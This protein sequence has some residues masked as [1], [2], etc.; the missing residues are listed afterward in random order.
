M[1]N[2]SKL[3]VLGAGLAC[4]DL[5]RYGKNEFTDLGGTA[6]NV[7]STLSLLGYDASFLYVDYKGKDSKYLKEEIIKRKIRLIQFTSSKLDAP[8][9][10]EYLDNG[11]HRFYTTCPECGKKL[12]EIQLPKLKHIEEHIKEIGEVNLFYFDRI[13]AGIKWLAE[14]NTNGWNFYEPNSTRLYNTL[15]E[16]SQYADILKLSADRIPI[17]Y[18]EKLKMDIG[19]LGPK[20]LIVSLGSNG[21]KYSIKQKDGNLSD[22]IYLEMR[23]N[24]KVI[25]SS[26]A[27]DF[28]A[29]VFLYYFLKE[30]PY[31]TE[32]LDV[33]KVTKFLSYAQSV[34]SISCKFIGAQGILESV[35]GVNI[36]NFLLNSCVEKMENKSLNFSKNCCGICKLKLL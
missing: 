35:E 9:I 29:S 5:I 36:L 34:A 21:L 2:L 16:N 22:W 8:R 20:L 7:I 12:N 18:I 4:I 15:L 23:E 33:A 6:V 31:Y 3:K 32:Y 10:V 14:Q 1:E 13:S 24:V 11:R 17:N 28:L 26:G 27:G 30:Y 25:D 19:V